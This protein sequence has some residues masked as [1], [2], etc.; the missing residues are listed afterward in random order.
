MAPPG[1][2]AGEDVPSD[3]PPSS[4]A[5]AIRSLAFCWLLLAFSP[6]CGADNSQPTA[7]PLLSRAQAESIAV[8][9]ARGGTILAADIEMAP[10]RILWSFD[11]A[12][13]GTGD[14]VAMD[15]DAN[16]GEIVAMLPNPPAD[17]DNHR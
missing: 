2:R 11:I 1:E 6:G 4:H 17:E 7:A 5:P 10:E 15:V 16:D 14:R 3:V 13:P 8:A 9:R 12:M